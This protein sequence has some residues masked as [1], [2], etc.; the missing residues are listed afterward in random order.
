MDD[1]IPAVFKCLGRWEVVLGKG[2]TGSTGNEAAHMRNVI[3]NLSVV[4]ACHVRFILRGG[5]EDCIVGKG[6]LM[7]FYEVQLD[8]V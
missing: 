1:A 6:K 3:L 4:F 8:I 7:G 5:E 2:K